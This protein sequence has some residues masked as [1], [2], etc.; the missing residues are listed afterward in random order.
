MVYMQ[1]LRA[2]Y[3]ES[4]SPVKAD[5]STRIFIGITLFQEEEGWVPNLCDMG[6]DFMH[7]Y[8]PVEMFI[9]CP[10]GIV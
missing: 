3:T 8:I 4:C 1:A 2:D 10:E 7:P 5:T 6:E 9:E